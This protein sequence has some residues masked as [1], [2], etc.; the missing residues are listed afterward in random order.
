MNLQII[1]AEF[2]DY[3]RFFKGYSKDTIRRY[4]HAITYYI[5][6]S[7][8]TSV[9]EVSSDNLQAFFFYG[10]TKRNW[11]ANTFIAHHKSLVVFFRWC[12]DKGYMAENPITKIEIPK[13]EYRLPPKLTKQETFRLLEVVYNYPY[14]HPFMRCRNHALF[15]TFIFAGI[16]KSELLNLKWTDVDIENSSLRINQGKGAKDRIIPICRTLA[17][18][19]SRYIEERKKL[20]KTCPE[21]FTSLRTNSGITDISLKRFVSK[22]RTVSNIEFSV[23][24]LRHTFATLMLEGGCDIY[25]LSRMMGHN[26]LKTTSI[27]LYASA[28]HLQSQISKHPLEGI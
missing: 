5:Q 25:S 4:R 6:I 28:A 9:D 19:L 1:A 14:N 23:H 13:L 11:K 8:I 26:D 12:R 15:S 16:R 22:L 27:Y 10:R 18:S 21:F 20:N 24:K 17:I 2:Y 3:S 7:K